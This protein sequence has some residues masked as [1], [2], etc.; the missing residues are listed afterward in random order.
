MPA[1]HSAHRQREITPKVGV[2]IFGR[3]RP[4]FDQ[5]W[6]REVRDRALA[7]LA[8]L[9]F[10]VIGADA[11]VSD[12]VTVHAALDQIVAAD[13][14]ALIVLQPS[15][16]DGQYAFSIMQRWTGPVILWTTP[17]RPG[18]GK[19]SSCGLVGQHLFAS[20]CCQ[21]N[22]SFELVYGD[23]NGDLEAT[24]DELLRAITLSSTI[25]ALRRGKVGLVGT[26]VPGFVDLAADPFLIHKTFGLQLHALSLPQFIERVGAISAQAVEA[27]IAEV[28]RLALPLSQPSPQPETAA[29]LS[30][31]SRFYLS[32]RELMAEFSLN[33]LALQCWPELP[34]MVGHWPY[35]AV[36]RISAQGA[37]L[38]IEGDVDGAI[39]SLI[40]TLLGIGPGFLTDWLEHDAST[41]FFWHPGMAPLDMCNEPGCDSGPTIGDHFN[42]VRPMVVDGPIRTGGP[43]TIARLWRCC[44]RYHMTAFEGQAI[45]PR[46]KITGNSLL[47]E[48][49]GDPVPVRFDRLIHAGMP[50]HVTIH[51]GSHVETFRRLARMLAIEWHA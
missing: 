45:A 5:E 10:T 28:Q 12:D 30:N 51:L 14:R 17:E 22:R 13:C 21:A 39:G 29:F 1:M 6:S 32:I 15:I 38:S 43:V 26:H 9:G 49:A 8:D 19:V 34:S 18:D 50:H 20:I 31:T 2:L 48:V 40:G 41:I 33:A 23:P 35:L 24:R 16:A 3:K 7:I 11:I 46:R 44:N 4:G 42:N 47:V 27:D 37:A 36:S 25:L